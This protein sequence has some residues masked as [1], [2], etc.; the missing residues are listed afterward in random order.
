MVQPI[1][2]IC[3]TASHS[4]NLDLSFMNQSRTY[5]LE[6]LNRHSCALRNFLPQECP[7]PQTSWCHSP[8]GT[9]G[10]NSPRS[11]YKIEIA[12]KNQKGKSLDRVK[13]PKPR[14][15]PSFGLGY[16]NRV[17]IMKLNMSTMSWWQKEEVSK[18]IIACA[19]G[20]ACVLHGYSTY[21]RI[22][23]IKRVKGCWLIRPTSENILFIQCPNSRISYWC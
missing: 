1:K 10:D 16:S 15:H 9:M 8:R 2:P 3:I 11:Y 14:W 23:Q 7:Q 6:D 19:G 22:D 17:K 20:K 18:N 4:I 13:I 12:S 21:P 5:N